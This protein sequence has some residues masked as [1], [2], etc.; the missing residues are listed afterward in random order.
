MANRWGE[1]EAVTGF[2]SLGSKITA[3]G[4]GGCCSHAVKKRLLLGRKAL[5]N[6][7]ITLPTQVLMNCGAGE[8]S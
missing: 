1:A 8:D 5:M 4:E 3:D 2:L 6:P 7:D